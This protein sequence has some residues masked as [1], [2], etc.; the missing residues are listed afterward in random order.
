M[1]PGSPQRTT[2][3]VFGVFWMV[4]STTAAQAAVCGADATAN[5]IIFGCSPLAATCTITGGSAPAGCELDFGNRKVTFTSGFDVGNSTLVVRAAQIQV[6]GSIKSRSDN[7]KR[8]G[9]IRLIATDSIVVSGTVDVSGDSA[10]LLRLQA[11][12]LIDL[13]S[14]GILRAR[15][16]ESSS[17]GNGASGGTIELVAGTSIT[18]RGTI[19]LGGGVGGG[20]GSLTTQAGT[21]TTFSQPVDATGGAGDG[22]DIDMIAGDD[23]TIERVIDVSSNTGGASGDIRVRAGADRVGGIKNGGAISRP[24]AAATPTPGM[25]AARS[26]CPR[27]VQSPSP[28]LCAPSARAPVE[29]AARS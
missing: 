24:T 9:T 17:T 21:N 25:T 13:Q 6:T 12:G 26:I 2:A 27:S 16:V 10:G 4:L 28:A 5:P 23:I 29:A 22:G 11:G 15:G 8:G 3:L 7:N 1:V 14:G 19:D 20:G 18:H